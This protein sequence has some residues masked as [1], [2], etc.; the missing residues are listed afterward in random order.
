MLHIRMRVARAAR[1]ATLVSSAATTLA[2]AGCEADLSELGDDPDAAADTAV[3]GG[4]DAASDATDAGPDGDT[5]TN[6]DTSDVNEGSD[7]SDASDVSTPFCEG[8]TMQVYG[9]ELDEIELWPDF[10]ATIADDTSP[11]GRRI[12]MSAERVPWLAHMAA[13]VQE[14]MA[15][16]DGA[17]GFATLGG[18]VVR[19]EAPIA[20]PP[21]GVAASTSSES[22]IFVDLDAEVPTRIAFEAQLSNG[23]RDLVLWPMWPL[24][25]GHRHAVIVT[26]AFGDVE[27]GE[28]CAAE[29]TRAILDGGADSRFDETT[30]AWLDALDALGV[31]RDDVAAITVFDAQN[32]FGILEAAGADARTRDVD[33]TRVGD[34]VTE[35]RWVRC[36]TTSTIADYRD[37]R[38][39]FDADVDALWTVPTTFWL[40]RDVVAPAP[41][42]MFGH[43]L[44]GG[45]GSG[46]QVAEQLVGEGFA[47]MAADAL[48]HGDHP[49]AAGDDPET[50][51][52]RFLGIDL[53]TIR[54]D[55]RALRGSFEQ[56]PL[57]RLQLLN[58]ALSHPDIDGDGLDDID[59]TRVGYIGESLG[60][61][62]GPLLIALSA[63]IDAAVLYIAGGRLVTFATDTENVDDYL[64]IIYRLVGGE[65]GFHR[66]VPVLQ[67]VVD[68]ADPS[69]W[70]TRLRERPSG[71]A[72][73]SVA[74]IV[75]LEDE[76]V[77]P[78]CARSM[79]RAMRLTQAQTVVEEVDGLEVA[80]AI[81]LVGNEADGAATMG[82]VQLD[83]VGPDAEP[84]R[85]GNVPWSTE[86][87]RV[88]FPFFRDWSAGALPPIFDAYGEG[89]GE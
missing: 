5:T 89:S 14:G 10:A 71:G 60:G 66:L 2:V 47:V 29:L 55:A 70:A 43:G 58:A 28:L 34:C 78:A 15:Q 54:L 25:A 88:V 68:T 7:T 84:A 1:L 53:D 85:H 82:Y 76:V 81:P 56:T 22:L 73:P 75:A 20:E 40:P 12:E 9:A 41:L 30:D 24:V 44:G 45:R 79:A 77:P 86:S 16:M 31:S 59:I 13:L 62:L 21:S 11:T 4:Q 65:A 23:G 61:L 35:E 18:I 3:D 32:D 74:M 39:V 83:F 36:E 50:T 6:F 87:K 72:T 38:A 33:L 26:R 51:S 49:S 37:D 19:F 52:L 57:D 80:E 42:I 64:P 8:R 67:S 69:A 48:E 46:R 63:D 17:S 27:G